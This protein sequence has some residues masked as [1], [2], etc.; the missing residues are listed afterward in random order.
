MEGLRKE[1]R[2]HIITTVLLIIGAI[3]LAGTAYAT[4]NWIYE[5]LTENTLTTTETELEF[6]ESNSEIINITDAIPMTDETGKTQG[7]K[8]DFQVRTKAPYDT[9]I[10]YDLVLEKL[11][12]DSGYTALKNNEVKVYIE[13]FQG[14]VVLAPTK[15]SE[16]NNYKLVS[17][18]NNHSSTNQEIINK[19]RLR[20]W[21]DKDVDIFDNQNK[22]IKFRININKYLKQQIKT[23]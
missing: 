8:F 22:Q 17:K 14:N 6:L 12:V 10:S 15:L 23:K 18:T 1:K 11:E 21:L 9:S 13:D 3:I 4:Y 16:L 5:G 2:K 19:Y 7:E 20:V